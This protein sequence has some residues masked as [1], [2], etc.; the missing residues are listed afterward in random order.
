MSREVT[1]QDIFDYETSFD[2]HM[3]IPHIQVVSSEHIL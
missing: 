1:L 2:V 3:V